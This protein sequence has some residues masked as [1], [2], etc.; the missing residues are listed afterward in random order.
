M[1]KAIRIASYGLPLYFHQPD[2]IKDKVIGARDRFCIPLQ[3]SQRIGH[4][5][6]ALVQPHSWEHKRV[7]HWYMKKGIKQKLELHSSSLK[8]CV[9]CRIFR[10]KNLKIRFLALSG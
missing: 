4:R 1:C 5:S 7:L 8:I 2:M 6:M 10:S 9:F 3:E